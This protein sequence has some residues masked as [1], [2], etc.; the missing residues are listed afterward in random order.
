VCVTLGFYTLP[1]SDP[2]CAGPQAP[3]QLNPTL[4]CAPYICCDAARCRHVDRT[5][6][7]TSTSAST[8]TTRGSTSTTPARTS[9]ASATRCSTRSGRRRSRARAGAL[10]RSVGRYRRGRPDGRS[11]RSGGRTRSSPTPSRRT[12]T[13]R[14][15]RTRSCASAPTAGSRRVSGRSS[16]RRRVCNELNYACDS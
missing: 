3:H 6:R 7:W 8:G 9:C 16:T 4:P 1:L 13:R 10:T 5:S 15:R 12:F 2:K 11:T 14:P